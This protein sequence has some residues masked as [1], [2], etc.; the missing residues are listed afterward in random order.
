ME[1]GV[2]LGDVLDKAGTAVIFGPDDLTALVDSKAHAIRL[3]LR[4][5]T[6]TTWTPRLL[7][8][9]N[10]IIK[11]LTDAGVTTIIG[12]LSERS[13][14]GAAQ[15][16]PDG[17]NVNAVGTSKPGSSG[18]NSFIP[19]YAAAV[20]QI[21]RGVRGITHWEVWNEP[22]SI[23]T[24]IQP[25]LYA[26]LLTLTHDTIKAAQA[27]SVV[28]TGGVFGQNNENLLP[29]SSGASYLQQVYDVLQAGG[30]GSTHPF[31]FDAIGQH[32]YL[33][34]GSVVTEA[35]L[36]SHLQLYLDD[37]AGVV[38]RN[39]RRSRPVYITEAG[40]STSAP[41]AFVTE[42]V[43]QNNLGILHSVYA[44]QP[45]GAIETACWFKLRDSP[46]GP[47]GLCTADG[48]RRK[49]AFAT[50]AGL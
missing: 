49:Q 3:E 47:F 26:T 45:V 17:W 50:F 32:L 23:K 4:I 20:R 8:L 2:A 34:Q 33:D 38:Q 21:V 27:D 5:G 29:A 35:E 39:E 19:R 41:G 9:Y 16:G 42:P 15:D 36:R 22:N 14:A 25:S 37:I 31:P 28:I 24:F 30:A 13:V 44:G 43:Q 6:Q 11:I 10:D 48:K 40:W 1:K 46:D 12:L 7:E 18:S